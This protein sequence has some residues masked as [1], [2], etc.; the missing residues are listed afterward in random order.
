[1][2]IALWERVFEHRVE[3]AEDAGADVQLDGGVG[4]AAELVLA[5][6]D[7]FAVGAQQA[8]DVR[9]ELRRPVRPSASASGWSS[10]A[11]HAHFR[12]S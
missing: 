7:G 8:F 1:M 5:I 11:V 4:D 3:A 9:A 2:A 12:A 6:D 10:H